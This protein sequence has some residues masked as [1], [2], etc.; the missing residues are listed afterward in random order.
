MASR[1]LSV[2]DLPTVQQLYASHVLERTSTLPSALQTQSSPPRTSAFNT[3]ISLIKH[4]I[5]KL[6]VTAIVNA[7]NTSLLGGGGVDGAIHAAAGPA[8][9]RECRDLDGCDTGDAKITGGAN[10]PASHVIHAVGPVYGVE[11][12]R[13][14]GREERLLARCYTR[15]LELASEVGSGQDVSIA[16]SGLSTGV[17]GYPKPMAARVA[18]AT[19]LKWLL[20]RR[21][22]KESTVQHVCFVCFEQADYDAYIKYLP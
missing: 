3:T 4:N 18:I 15:S 19:V 7:A 12:R 10:L 6:R 5:T 20:E 14:A 16:F 2:S 17:Y 8:L 22:K 13:E 1:V 21:E 11:R 9:L